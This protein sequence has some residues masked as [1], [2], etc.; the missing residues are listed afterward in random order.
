V[1]E[2]SGRKG[3]NNGQALERGAQEPS[4][5]I[6][7][8]DHPLFRSAISY[9]LEAQPDLEVVAE[10]SDGREALELCRRLGPELVLMDLGMPVMDGVAA[11]SAIKWESPETLVLVL[12]ALD[13]SNSLSECLRAGAEGY[14]LKD[15]PP[16]RLIDAVRRALGGEHPLDEKLATG[17]LMSLIDR[18]IRREEGRSAHASASEGDLR[19][20][21]GSRSADSLTPREIEVLRLVARGETNRQ[22]SRTLF[23]SV[24]TVKRHVR[25]IEEKLGVRD[26]VQ[27]AVRAAELSLLDERSGV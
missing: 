12:T 1:G 2:D 19:H 26:R 23:I 15:A 16:E 10:A 20:G 14:I 9:T 13:E 17:L 24:S 18:K 27:A 22:I 5:I 4:R 6:V 21:G 8:D 25:H 7:A 3:E 11:T